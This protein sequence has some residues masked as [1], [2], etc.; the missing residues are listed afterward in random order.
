MDQVLAM[1]LVLADHEARF[2]QLFRGY[3]TCILRS[4][5]MV[6]PAIPLM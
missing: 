1:D 6:C 2:E 5:K 3:H 4:T